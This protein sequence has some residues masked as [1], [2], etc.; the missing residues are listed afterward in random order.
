MQ[1]QQSIEAKQCRSH[2]DAGDDVWNRSAAD[3]Q[4]T[5]AVEIVVDCRY[6]AQRAEDV[7]GC[8]AQV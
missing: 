3:M 4:A 1:P 5:D 8:A 2:A 6:G 7:A